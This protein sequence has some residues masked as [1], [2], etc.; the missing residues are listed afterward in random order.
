MTVAVF[1]AAFYF[2][3]V[4]INFPIDLWYGYPHERQFALVKQGA[5][6]VG[7]AIGLLA[8]WGMGC[9]SLRGRRCC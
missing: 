2:I 3:Y 8:L 9:R 1:A 4:L 7:G 6:R 5:A